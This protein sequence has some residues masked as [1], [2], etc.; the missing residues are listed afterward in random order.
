MSPE[1]CDTKKHS[2][3]VAD[4]HAPGTLFQF[5]CSSSQC[6][7]TR[8]QRDHL[9]QYNVTRWNIRI[10]RSSSGHF[11]REAV[12]R[13][14]RKKK[15]LSAPVSGWNRLCRLCLW[16][17]RKKNNSQCGAMWPFEDVP[18]IFQMRA[19]PQEFN[20][21]LKRPMNV[22]PSCLLLS[23][24]VRSL[25]HPGDNAVLPLPSLHRHCYRRSNIL[26][27]PLQ[28]RNSAFASRCEASS[29][30]KSRRML[31]FHNLLPPI[32]RPYCPLYIELASDIMLAQRFRWTFPDAQ[33]H[34][35]APLVAHAGDVT[36]QLFGCSASGIA[37]KKCNRRH[38]RFTVSPREQCCVSHTVCCSCSSRC[39][40]S[41]V[42]FARYS[43]CPTSCAWEVFL[44]SMNL[45]MFASFH[46]FVSLH[47]LQL[48][49]QSG[50][51]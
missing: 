38:V 8:D 22:T 33:G 31:A 35:Y 11:R 16:R 40:L 1:T 10:S 48:L 49:G 50:N 3:N 19:T 43:I 24:S 27:L 5:C 45:F 30:Q 21:P 20:D 4:E 51:S 29:L 37:C 9:R 25:L 14:A 34:I 42:S 17:I 2:K 41:S 44:V 12:R 32:P 18:E 7:I 15:A 36:E 28:A 26:L 47:V 13:A 39:C 46:V 6:N 23:F